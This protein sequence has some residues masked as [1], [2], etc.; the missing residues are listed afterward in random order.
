MDQAK[1]VDADKNPL[2]PCLLLGDPCV[3]CKAKGEYMCPHKNNLVDASTRVFD[4]SFLGAL[5]E[6]GQQ[7]RLWIPLRRKQGSRSNGKLQLCSTELESG[8]YGRVH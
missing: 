3:N 4:L 2:M 7:E 5:E 6:R 1:K 8:L